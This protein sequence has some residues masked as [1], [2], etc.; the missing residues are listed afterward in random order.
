MA[1]SG[2]Y[3]VVYSSVVCWS[4][5][6]SRVVLKKNVQRDEWIGIATVT[7]GLA[8][9]ALGES[10]GG[11][12]AYIILIGSLNTFIGAG[13]YGTTYVT[14][15]FTLNLPEHPTPRELCIKVGT[16][17]VGIIAVYM[18]F[19]VFP[20]W[21]EIVMTPIKEAQGDS[22]TIVLGL[23]LYTISQLA[24]GFTYFMMLRSIGAVSTGVMQSLRAVLVFALSSMVFCS[25]QESQCFDLRRGISTMFVV[26][27]VLYYSWAKSQS[28]FAVLSRIDKVVV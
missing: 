25:R 20:N 22:S 21:N 12:H 19:Y 14:G 28:R 6:M 10:H 15:E 11:K 7:F 24:H 17:C 3:Q 27:G 26:V 23:L 16:T 8:F 2:I 5:L 18:T 4:A 13:F 1:G 9:S